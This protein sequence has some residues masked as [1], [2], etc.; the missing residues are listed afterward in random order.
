MTFLRRCHVEMHRGVALLSM[1]LVLALVSVITYRMVFEN[2]QEIRLAVT[3]R[4]QAQ[5]SEY[6]SFGLDLAMSWLYKDWQ[7]DRQENKIVDHKGE[8]WA[9]ADISVELETGALKINIADLMGRFN[10][11][12]LLGADGAVDEQQFALFQRLLSSLDLETEL[13]IAIVDWID[14][15][16]SSRS[17]KTEDLGYLQSDIP[18]RAA[19]RIL[20]HTSELR[21]IRNI[22]H[23]S[24]ELLLPHITVLPEQGTPININTVSALLLEA[25]MP[26]LA[27]KD[28]F[29]AMD[30]KK[31]G[32]SA[33]E[34]FLKHQVS[35]G[36]AEA[37]YPISVDSEYFLLESQANVNDVLS[38]WIAMAR[39]SRESGD[40][41]ILWREKVPFWRLSL[42]DGRNSSLDDDEQKTEV[43]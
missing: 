1:L 12:N 40:L 43:I 9:Q 14:P 37:S 41:H 17:Y 3:L 4:D 42:D 7:S 13:A 10:L 27:A 21:L 2:S 15:D 5:S 22:D 38:G 32:F 35:A 28:V 24:F 23:A 30:E 36:V 6:A 19:N 26:G 16:I 20:S 8:G 31:G 11:N 34:E 25:V 39:R 29:Q 18:Y 33:V